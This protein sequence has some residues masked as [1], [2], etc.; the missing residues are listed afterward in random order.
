[1]AKRPALQKIVKVLTG[2]AAI[3]FFVPTRTFEG[4][5]IFVA[6]LVL[7][8]TCFVLYQIASAE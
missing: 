6:S 5:M 4:F 8:I 7:L 3:G 2:I 1:M